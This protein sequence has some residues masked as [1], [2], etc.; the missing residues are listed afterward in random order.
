VC[1]AC[2]KENAIPSQ[3]E[4]VLNGIVSMLALVRTLIMDFEGKMFTESVKLFCTRI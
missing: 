2:F 1:D 3:V 4:E